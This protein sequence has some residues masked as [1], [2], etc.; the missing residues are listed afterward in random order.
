MTCIV[1]F[2]NSTIETAQCTS[3]VM[4]SL[5]ESQLDGP[6]SLCVFRL[7]LCA[8]AFYL[9]SLADLRQ[10]SAAAN[11][12]T[13]STTTGIRKRFPQCDVTHCAYVE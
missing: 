4:R 11:G 6:K 3:G 8:F 2:D 10:P 9:F 1:P 13:P 12:R 5:P 7:R